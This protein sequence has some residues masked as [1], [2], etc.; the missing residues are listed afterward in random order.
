MPFTDLFVNPFTTGDDI[1]SDQDL[2]HS[3]AENLYT[4]FH[5]FHYAYLVLV[6]MYY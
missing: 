3:I 6:T 5:Y 1:N 4:V 2:S